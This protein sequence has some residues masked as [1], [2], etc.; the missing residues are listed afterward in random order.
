MLAMN[1]IETDV[2]ESMIA[3]ATLDQ[4]QALHSVLCYLCANNLVVDEVVAFLTLHPE[5]LLLE[6]TS[7]ADSARDIL[8][9]H[10][11][12]C[13]CFAAGCNNNRFQILHALD[14][15]FEFYQGQYLDMMQNGETA[16]QDRSRKMNLHTG[17]LCRLE[18]VIRELQ[19]DE[20]AIRGAIL[21]STLERRTFGD[22]LRKVEYQERSL[23]RRPLA[24]LACGRNDELYS[25]RSVLEY[26]M[27]V[28]SA[29]I[30][31]L[32]K[33]R[34]AVSREIRF[35]HRMQVAILKKIF[36]GCQRH[37]CET[38]KEQKPQVKSRK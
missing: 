17:E 32:E 29:K 22:E 9:M 34:E 26:Y 6:G 1:E 4:I 19:F 11:R 36:S 16:V 21:D 24:R 2:T 25:Q 35:S 30:A 31:T 3:L 12:H 20:I 23:S 27:E 38:V 33:K 14:R 28:E 10:I 7:P 37:V 8:E 5:C 18:H 15:G 13:T